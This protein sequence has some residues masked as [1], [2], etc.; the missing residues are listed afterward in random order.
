MS[1]Q[2]C[3][4]LLHHI[5]FLLENSYHFCH[6]ACKV[7][8]KGRNWHTSPWYNNSVYI[9]GTVVRI[10]CSAIFAMRSSLSKSKR[11][12]TAIMNKAAPLVYKKKKKS[13]TWKCVS[14]YIWF[15]LRY[16][17]DF[18]RV[19]TLEGPPPELVKRTLRRE[20]TTRSL[21]S[22]SKRVLKE[23]PSV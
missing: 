6:F 11:Q 17:Y 21:C 8:L 7:S 22:N 16:G 15:V 2:K 14:W 1:F 20:I 10:R 3:K 19:L 18:S 12:I 5:S 23:I 4:N 9:S 13:S